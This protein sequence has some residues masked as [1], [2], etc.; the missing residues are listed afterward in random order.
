M[1]IRDRYYT[2]NEDERVAVASRADD[3]YLAV[4]IELNF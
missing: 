2:L 4:G 3:K 1:C